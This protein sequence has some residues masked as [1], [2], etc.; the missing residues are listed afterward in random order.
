MNSK[1]KLKLIIEQSVWKQSEGGPTKSLQMYSSSKEI[2]LH[3]K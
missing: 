1:T 3:T 2:N